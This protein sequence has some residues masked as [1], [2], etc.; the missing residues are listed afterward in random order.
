MVGA[1]WASI[2]I[3]DNETIPL[4]SFEGEVIVINY[5]ATWCPPCI[6]EMPNFQEVYNA[7]GEE[8]R[9]IFATSDEQSKVEAFMT[10]NGYDLPIYYYQYLPEA[11]MHSSIPTTFI[12]NRKGE[13]RF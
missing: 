2:L 3:N 10:K 5:W 4:G 13:D 7:Y 8:V 11:F 1:D 9:F 6:A 12:V